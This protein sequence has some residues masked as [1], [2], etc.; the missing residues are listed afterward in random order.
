MT[1]SL[2]LV[3]LS[4]ILLMS[5]NSEEKKKKDD[6]IKYPE[7][8]SLVVKDSNL[9]ESM[10]KGKITYNELCITCHLADGKG[11]ANAFPPLA[12]SDYLKNNQDK[13]II[14]VKKGMS[15]EITVNGVAYNNVMAPLGLTDEEVANVMNYINN[16]WGNNYGEY[17]SVEQV[18]KITAE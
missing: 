13:S 16:S 14:G 18:S 10:D 2:K 3:A 5:C 4:A 7:K 6:K 9:K 15:G 17:I 12:N 1:K 11:V 8:T